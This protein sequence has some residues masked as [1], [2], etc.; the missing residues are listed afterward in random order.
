MNFSVFH[1]PYPYSKGNSA[2]SAGLVTKF[3]L[4]NKG[5]RVSPV[6]ITPNISCIALQN[7]AQ[8]VMILPLWESFLKSLELIVPSFSPL[9]FCFYILSAAF[10]LR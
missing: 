6:A 1:S 9:P 5:N 4:G 2:H 7:S 8:P 3:R 10:A